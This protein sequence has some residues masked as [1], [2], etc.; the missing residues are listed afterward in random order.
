MSVERVG[1]ESERTIA[2][3][4]Y[5]LHLV[6]AVAGITSIVGLILNYVRRG[7]YGEP[8]ASHHRWMIRSFWW[9]IVWFVIGIV[10]SFILIGWVIC[11]FA[12]VWYVYRHVRGLIALANGESMPG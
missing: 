11:L 5:V 7:Q 1:I 4:A 2:L 6:G 12:W 9:A 3:V 10:T 8:L